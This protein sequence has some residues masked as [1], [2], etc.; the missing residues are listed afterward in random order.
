[1]CV[2]YTML[3]EGNRSN[4]SVRFRIS[5]NSRSHTVSFIFS[6]RYLGYIVHKFHSERVQNNMS[7]I[8]NQAAFKALNACYLTFN[9]NN[10]KN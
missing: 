8:E 2:I 9:T 7:K 3:C 4:E 6:F 10:R 5:R 1:M